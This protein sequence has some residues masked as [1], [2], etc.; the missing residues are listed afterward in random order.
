MWE[1]ID[2]GPEC[3]DGIDNDGDGLVDI[4]DSGCTGPLD[5]SERSAE[6][7]CD[8]GTDNDDDGLLDAADPEC[9]D[10]MTGAETT[11]P[12]PGL[13]LGLGAGIALLLAS[14]RA[15]RRGVRRRVRATR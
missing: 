15:D 10:P 14:A 8:D 3:G 9:A 13:G 12:E 6:I 2:R 11:V 4:G 5:V 1:R 7:V